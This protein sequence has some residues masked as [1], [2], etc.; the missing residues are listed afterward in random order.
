MAMVNS[1]LSLWDIR[2]TSLHVE[3]EVQ[4]WD[5]Q[6]EERALRNRIDLFNQRRYHR[7]SSN[8]QA[9][10]TANASTQNASTAEFDFE[11]YVPLNNDLLTVLATNDQHADHDLPQ[12][13]KRNY[14]Q[15]LNDEIF[16]K[17]EQTDWD[18]LLQ[19]RSLV[20]YWNDCGFIQ[21]NKER[22]TK[23]NFQQIYCALKRWKSIRIDV[24]T[25]RSITFDHHVHSNHFQHFLSDPKEQR[26]YDST[27]RS[28]STDF[29]ILNER[30]NVEREKTNEDRSHLV[31][32][33]V[34]R[35]EIFLGWMFTRFFLLLFRFISMF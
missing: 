15:W 12:S 30:E 4:A 3:Q 6:T 33:A 24:S 8:P 5:F 26:E 16:N 13:F 34:M 19:S 20:I 23:E 29:V 22:T 28:D 21:W 7:T 32:M 14:E 35:S 2:R 27:D 1:S 31:V 10:Q 11:S 25:L 9:N 18:A 17:E